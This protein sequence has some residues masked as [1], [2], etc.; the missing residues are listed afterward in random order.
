LALLAWRKWYAGITGQ[1]DAATLRGVEQ[2]ITNTTIAQTL[3]Q[4]QASTILRGTVRLA[5]TSETNTGTDD[6][7]AVTPD[8]LAGSILGTS[9]IGVIAVDFT[10]DVSVADGKAYMPIPAWMNGMNLVRAQAMVITA[11]TTNPTT[12]DIY[13]VTDSQDMLSAAISIAS[14][15]TVGTVGTI[16]TTYD[17]LATNDVLRVDV[18]TVSTTAPK[19]LL[20]VLEARLP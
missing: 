17:D 1:G 12:I 10:T 6:A 14:G 7:I 4:T 15:A 8:G 9:G 5:T 16:N 11:G 3:D 13:N 2:H 18:T 20:V 19:G